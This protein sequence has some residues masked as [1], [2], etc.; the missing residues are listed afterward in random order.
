MGI[1]STVRH[2]FLHKDLSDYISRT[3]SYWPFLC[4]GLEEFEG[5]LTDAV[6]VDYLS[7]A[8]QN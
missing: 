8:P 3:G 6:A 1:Q 7:I 4:P 5:P 2:N